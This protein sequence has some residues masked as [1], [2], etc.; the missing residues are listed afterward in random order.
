MARRYLVGIHSDKEVIVSRRTPSRARSGNAV[1]VNEGVSDVTV[2][3]SD[4]KLPIAAEFDPPIAAAELPPFEHH[5]RRR[6]AK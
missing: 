6:V 2:A 5:P 4:P 1:K 3:S